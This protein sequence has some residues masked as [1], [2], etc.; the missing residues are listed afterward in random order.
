MSVTLTCRL[1]DD[2]ESR[3]WNFADSDTRELT[4]GIHR[5][6]GKFIPQIAR[7][8][9]ELLTQ[10]GGLV[11]DPFCGSGTTLLEAALLRRRA[12]GIDLN[13][14]AALIARAKCTPIDEPCRHGLFR[15][16]ADSV[17][18]LNDEDRFPLFGQPSGRDRS[19]EVVSMGDVRL[20]DPWYN[21]W[22]DEGGLKRLLWLDAL[23]HS[24]SDP[25]CRT[26]AI[27]ALSDILRRCSHAA[28]GYPNVMYDK[29]RRSRPD[30]IPL[31]LQRLRDILDAVASLDGT[32]CGSFAEVRHAAA[33]RTGLPSASADAIVTHPPYIGSIPYAEYGLLSLKWLGH[34]P[35]EVDR[36]LTGGQRQ[37][38]AVVPRFRVGLLGMLTEA[39]RVL[40]P[41]GYM[42]TMVGHPLVR[43]V[44]INLAEL[45]CELAAHAGFE[46]FATARRQGVNR[47]A[48]KM[49]DEDLL[50][51][52]KTI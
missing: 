24:I 10:P 6:S 16:F 19:V 42:F 50:F 5:Y 47:R 7:T 27:V 18:E 30:P 51:F 22:F 25:D 15:F 4:H 34:E 20:R 31:F 14:L 48:N 43:G 49:G 38:S 12:I 9:I 39:F 21:K 2:I 11:V 41:G 13:P 46:L 36:Q 45:T 26:L 52:S 1:R 44:R 23:V 33:Q 29:R 8:A 40:R 37:S 28:G 17:A 35:K 32:D 3:N